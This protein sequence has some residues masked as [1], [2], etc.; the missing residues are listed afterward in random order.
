MSDAKIDLQNKLLKFSNSLA[1][2]KDA[3]ETNLVLKGVVVLQALA[4]L[5]CISII[6][7]K[8]PKFVVTPPLFTQELSIQGDLVSESYQTS[9]AVFIAEQI[10]NIT[11]SRMDLTVKILSK[12]IP[13]SEWKSAK[14]QMNA[15]LSRLRA[16]KI[17]ERFVA[18][19]V[20]IDPITKIV[21]VFGEKETVSIRT[22]QS[23]TIKWTFELK[24]GSHL[25]SPKILHLAQYE[26]APRKK[27]RIKAYKQEVKSNEAA[28]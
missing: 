17:E 16:R 27:D 25:G 8:E 4:I 15:Q 18:T 22:G 13:Q 2:Y 3:I 14:E 12:M 10:G 26:G 28:Q 23:A 9:W 24:I 19:D 7:N 5:W 6:S 20:S 21:W 1:K 11:P